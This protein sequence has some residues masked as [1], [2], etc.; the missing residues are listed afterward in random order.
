LFVTRVLGLSGY[1]AGPSWSLSLIANV[2][3][4]TIGDPSAA[5]PFTAYLTGT[6]GGTVTFLNTNN[7]PVQVSANLN[8]LYRLQDGSTSTLQNDF[9]TY[10]SAIFNSPATS[11]TT[12][13]IYGSIPQSDYV[14]L[15]GAYPTDYSPYGCENNFEANDLSAA[16]NDAWSNVGLE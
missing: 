3:P 11:A 14:S 6:T 13:V 4:T 15:I 1:D 10:L 2:D 8:V 9:N 5:V 16:S 12:A 7:L